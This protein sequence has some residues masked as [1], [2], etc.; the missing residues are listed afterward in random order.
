MASVKFRGV[1][2]P[3]EFPVKSACRVDDHE[4]DTREC[5]GDLQFRLAAGARDFALPLGRVP[6]REN[7]LASDAR[8]AD[9]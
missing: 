5:S 9:L 8:V 3:Q 1:R 4:V 6:D 7:R 2:N